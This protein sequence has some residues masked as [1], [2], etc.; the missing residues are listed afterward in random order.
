MT[1]I[2]S[3]DKGCDT[4]EHGKGNKRR[5]DNGYR[6]EDCAGK[7]A[8]TEEEGAFAR[9]GIGTVHKGQKPRYYREGTPAED[10]IDKDHAKEQAAGKDRD[11]RAFVKDKYNGSDAK[12]KYQVDGL[13][14][15]FPH[16]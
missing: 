12:A 14:Q 9:Q 11:C 5:H 4:V 1:A 3:P 2:L 10:E 15:E 13:P 7:R 16:S 8:Y 6:K